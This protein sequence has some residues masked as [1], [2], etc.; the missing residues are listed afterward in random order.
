MVP[1]S[2]YPPTHPH[3]SLTH[4]LTPSAAQTFLTTYLTQSQ[5]NPH[6]HPDALLSTSGIT[7]SAQSG[8]IGGLALHHL[9][10]IAAGL[11]GENLIAETPDELAQFAGEEATATLPAGDDARVDGVINGGNG[12]STPRKSALKRTRSTEEVAQWAEQS[13]EAGAFGEEAMDAGLEQE[14]WQDQEEYEHEQRP[15][16]GDVGERS[17]APVVRQNGAPPTITHVEDDD[18]DNGGG[19]GAPGKA[20]TESE[21]LARRA[22]K[23]AKKKRDVAELV[24]KKREGNAAG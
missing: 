13:S 7:Y 21:K 18:Y 4:T 20:L 17:A 16:V 15:L 8:P 5:T 14:G 3:P 6:L 24:R 19:A 2:S 11:R 10:R 1:K 23:K 12:A 22:A 9:K